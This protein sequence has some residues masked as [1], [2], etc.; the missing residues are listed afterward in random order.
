MRNAILIDKLNNELSSIRSPDLAV[1]LKAAKSIDKHVLGVLTSERL[2]WLRHPET[3]TVL[4]AALKTEDDPAIQGM[5]IRSLGGIYER[6]LKDP[7]IFDSIEPF[8]ATKN[9]R[10]LF[11]CV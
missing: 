8:Y 5:L 9:P 11:A 3:V 1:R 10:V 4:R 7:R 6:C 2:L